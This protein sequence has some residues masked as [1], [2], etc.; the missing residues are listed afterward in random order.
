MFAGLPLNMIIAVDKKTGGIGYEGKLPWHCPDD[1][2]FFR[3]MTIGHTCICGYRTFKDMPILNRRTIIPVSKDGRN[4]SFTIEELESE[5]GF[6]NAFN[7]E[8]AAGELFL[9]GGAELYLK[10]LKDG[11][12]DT[13]YLSE[14]EF[15]NKEYE[16]DTYL[17]YP[18]DE[19][20]KEEIRSISTEDYELKIWKLTL[21]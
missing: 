9:I 11:K 15:K 18:F 3:E 10:F 7:N 13:V 8:T 12:V 5:L 21:K 16:Y 4:A 17:Q 2:K 19:F 6:A 14:I 1:L 20:N